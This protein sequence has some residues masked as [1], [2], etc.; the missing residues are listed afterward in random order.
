MTLVKAQSPMRSFMNGIPR[1]RANSSA[2]R[3]V[4]NLNQGF[5][6]EVTMI[7][8]ELMQGGAVAILAL[9]LGAPAVAQNAA[10]APAAGAA[11]Q[12]S[13][14][15]VAPPPADAPAGAA[16][17]PTPSDPHAG[18]PGL[19]GGPAG[20]PTAERGNP[21]PGTS[22]AIPTT[23]PAPVAPLAE[24]ARNEPA[25]NAATAAECDPVVSLANCV[26]DPGTGHVPAD[27]LAPAETTVP[28]ASGDAPVAS[29]DIGPTQVEVIEYRCGDGKTLQ[30][31]YVRGAGEPN[32]AVLQHDGRL[33]ALRQQ[34][35]ASGAI[36]ASDAGG[37][38]LELLTKGSEAFLQGPGGARL[39][40]DCRS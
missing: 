17:A 19:N 25:E 3:W 36:Y 18:L 10:S 28:A 21:R 9:M 26:D 4:G 14:A 24:R 33:V 15:V 39:L 5:R 12:V 38:S 34:V 27:G 30:V 16:S 40:D 13:E 1:E 6:K 32:F 22:T 31:A 37:A 2:A 35:S 7:R 11:P 8:S 29:E 23:N 20:S